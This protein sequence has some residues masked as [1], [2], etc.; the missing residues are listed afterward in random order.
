LD[1]KLKVGDRVVFVIDNYDPLYG[2]AGQRGVIVVDAEDGWFDV[3]MDDV[4]PECGE[5]V[6]P[7]W[8][9][10]PGTLAREEA[11]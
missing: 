10:A 5:D 8:Y 2:R 11:E 4:D 3:Q 6:K 7:K 9:V 1:T